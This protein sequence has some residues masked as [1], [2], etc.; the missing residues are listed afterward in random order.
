M[1][2]TFANVTGSNK[3]HT[4]MPKICVAFIALA[5]AFGGGAAVAQT[6]APAAK[7]A[8]K[9]GAGRAAEPLTIKLERKKVTQADGKE[10]LVNAAEAKPGD[11][12]EE[13]A[14]YTNTSKK[15]LRADATLPVPQYT[16]LIVASVKPSNV[17]ASIDGTTF[18]PMPL[19]RKVKQANGVVL[20]Q[21]VPV[22]EYRFLR[23][24]GVDLGPEK[25]F[26][27]SARFRLYDNTA[28]KAPG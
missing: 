15:N 6:S 10:L 16:E 17:L 4:R 14:T 23:W 5:I 19:K 21:I 12:I 3:A 18:S 13:T 11:V 28:N 20:E 2:N 27:V 9:A 7:P 24:K 26:V 1:L 22:I 25:I 8:A